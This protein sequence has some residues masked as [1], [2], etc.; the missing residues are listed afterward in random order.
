MKG[1]KGLIKNNL[2]NQFL[3][4][5]LMFSYS[6][7]IVAAE[8]IITTNLL[9]TLP[10]AAEWDKD[11]LTATKT[12]LFNQAASGGTDATVIEKVKLSFLHHLIA[13]ALC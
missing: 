9:Q 8:P 12:V 5:I 3:F 4:S 10:T 11:L 2:R 1:M 13:Q 6:M 7:L